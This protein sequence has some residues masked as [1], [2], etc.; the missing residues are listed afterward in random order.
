MELIPNV[1]EDFPYL[2]QTKDFEEVWNAFEM[3][4]LET[5]EEEIADYEESETLK[6]DVYPYIISWYEGLVSTQD[7]ISY[8]KEV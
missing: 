4:Q 6:R 3:W 7:L 2:S 1:V 5:F 8:Y